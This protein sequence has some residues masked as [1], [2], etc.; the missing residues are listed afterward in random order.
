MSRP[1][2]IETRKHSTNTSRWRPES[3]ASSMAA[4]MSMVFMPRFLPRRSGRAMPAARPGSA[5]SADW[6][7]TPP[8]PFRRSRA[9]PAGRESAGNRGRRTPARRAP[10]H[11][12]TARGG[13]AIGG[14]QR[15]GRRQAHAGGVVDV[16][17]QADAADRLDDLGG[18]AKIV[19]EV[20]GHIQRIDRLD[21]DGRPRG[22]QPVASVGEV[23]PQGRQQVVA[24]LSGRDRPR[25]DVDEGRPQGLDVVQGGREQDGEVELRPSADACRMFRRHRAIN[26]HHLHARRLLRLGQGGRGVGVGKLQLHGRKARV[27]GRGEAVEQRILLEHQAEVGGE[28]R[29][30]RQTFGWSTMGVSITPRP[31]ISIRTTSPAK[32]KTGGFWKAP[33]PVV[34]PV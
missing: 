10:A 5:L 34:V 23:G 27:T 9:Q 22:R 16:E 26:Q 20:A 2:S 25:Q 33:Q 12:R 11:R 15:F 31:V 18:Q 7:G 19:D 28:P 6:A 8:P 24:R 4:P 21:Q 30:G 17:L 3:L 13:R 1:S 32:R 29:H 14:R